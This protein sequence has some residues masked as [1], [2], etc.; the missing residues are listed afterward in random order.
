MLGSTNVGKTSLIRRYMVN[1]YT[2]FIFSTYY[3]IKIHKTEE[4]ISYETTEYGWSWLCNN[5][6]N[7]KM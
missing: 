1:Q 6:I 5:F 2:I 3:I 4:W 7:I